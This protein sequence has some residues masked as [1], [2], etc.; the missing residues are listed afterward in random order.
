MKMSQEENIGEKKRLKKEASLQLF[1][2]FWI[3]IKIVICQNE[4]L[5][6]AGS[7]ELKVFEEEMNKLQM[8]VS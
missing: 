1:V 3:I 4:E 7:R 6:K 8:K 5:I 2:H